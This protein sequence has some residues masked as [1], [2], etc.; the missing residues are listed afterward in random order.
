MANKEDV[1]LLVNDAN[2]SLPNYL[3]SSICVAYENGIYLI[4]LKINE[5]HTLTISVQS[6]EV[7]G[8]KFV[9]EMYNPALTL[10]AQ[11]YEKY[12]TK[13]CNQYADNHKLSIHELGTLVM[14]LLD[15]AK[16]HSIFIIT[17]RQNIG[18]SLNSFIELIMEAIQFRKNY[19][20][21]HGVDW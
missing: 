8:I 15:Y 6:E 12:I 13:I 7:S 19:K 17:G 1:L 20:K 10:L 14:F 3:L 18:G 11:K 9:T 2:I 4:K 21:E 5:E 16:M